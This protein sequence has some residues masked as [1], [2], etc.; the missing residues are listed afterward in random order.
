MSIS[1]LSLIHEILKKY[2]FLERNP[3]LLKFFTV[4]VNVS[5][6][7]KVRSILVSPLGFR[8]VG[9]PNSGVRLLFTGLQMVVAGVFL[10]VRTRSLFT[11]NPLCNLLSPKEGTAISLPQEQ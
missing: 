9:R 1:I 2:Y 4:W 8:R 6:C 10:L 5:S 7:W 3:D 11:E